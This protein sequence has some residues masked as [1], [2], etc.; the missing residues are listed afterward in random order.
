VPYPS[1]EVDGADSIHSELLRRYASA[2]IAQR[3]FVYVDSRIG[4]MACRQQAVQLAYFLRTDESRGK[5]LLDRALAS[6]YTGCSQTVLA[7]VARD[8]K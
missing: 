1:T 6:R 4:R 8:Q 2:Q 3:L 5:T 7:D